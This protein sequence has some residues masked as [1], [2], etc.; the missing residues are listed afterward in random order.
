MADQGKPL[1]RSLYCLHNEHC[2][3]QKSVKQLEGNQ[4]HIT[5]MY[6]TQVLLYWYVK[7]EVGYNL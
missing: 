3:Y 5:S 6:C 1:D 2:C 4:I 7:E